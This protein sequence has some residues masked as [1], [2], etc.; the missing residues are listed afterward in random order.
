LLRS[1][2][3][4]QAD[5][6]SFRSALEMMVEGMEDGEPRTVKVTLEMD[7]APPDSRMRMAIVGAPFEM[8]F[9][10]ISKDDVTYVNLGD[11]WTSFQ[12]AGEAKMDARIM[13]TQELEDL[14]SVATDARVASRRLVK[15]VE[16]DIVQFTIPPAKMLEL[17]AKANLSS[18][19]DAKDVEMA[20]FAGEIAVGAADR[21]MRQLTVRMEGAERNQP[22]NR[23]SFAMTMTVWDIDA[24][25]IVIEA[26]PNARPGDFP[27]PFGTPP[28]R[29]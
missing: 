6:K 11:E 20:S 16:C 1:V 19:E 3:L 7:S 15:G 24:P 27:F 2:G 8:V 28:T 13:D 18:I 25:N 17:A 21:I 10:L 12:G 4:K 14:L 23:F 22:H 9:E 29:R 26:P 5:L